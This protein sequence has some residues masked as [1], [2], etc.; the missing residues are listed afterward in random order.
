MSEQFRVA[1]VGATGY[2]GSETIRLLARHPSFKVT[3][4]TSGRLAGRPLREECPWLGTDLVLERLDPNRLDVDFIVLAQENGFAMEHAAALLDRARV[5]DLSADFRLRDHNVYRE[6]YGREHS[7]PDLQGVYGL[8]ELEDRNAIAGARL[9]A[10][11]GCYPTAALLALSPLK[12]SILGVPVVDAKSGVSGA[13]RSRQETDYLFAEL[14]SGMKAYGVARHRHTPE[15]EQG[16]GQT[17]RFTPHLVPI[18][19]GIHATCHLPVAETTV[20]I[21][22]ERYW[23]AYRSENFVRIVPAPPSTKQV[24][25]SNR[26][27]IFVDYDPRTSMAVVIT[28]IDN[29]VK[30][31]AG[32]A[33]QNLNLMAGLPETTGLPLDGQWP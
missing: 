1:V 7:R 29:L 6:Y 2:G 5:V 16:L 23:D 33:I 20:E 12:G 30:G 4:A 32:Q 10:N 18:S 25:G 27:D 14:S 28:V 26:C 24:Q 11:P 17:V 13:G 15:I 8:P 22:R 21:L 9:V 3:V 19:R 31:M